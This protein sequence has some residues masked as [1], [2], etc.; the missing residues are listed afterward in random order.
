MPEVARENPNVVQPCVANWFDD[1]SD[2]TTT[3]STPYFVFMALACFY[4]TI[5]MS[6]LLLDQV[7]WMEMVGLQ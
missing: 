7:W 4:Y 1:V 3:S 5:S 2:H 6:R